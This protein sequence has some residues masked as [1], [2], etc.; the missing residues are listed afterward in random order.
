MPA[1]MMKLGDYTFSLDTAVYQ[2]TSRTSQ[3]KWPEQPRIGTNPYLQF[4]GSGADTLSL[5]G[6]I[7]PTFKGGVK[8]VERMREEAVKG[9]PLQLID[10]SGNL[11]G[12]W[13]ITS[14]KE[15]TSEFLN[16]GIPQKINFTLD[17]KF[18]DK[19]LKRTVREQ[20]AISG[21]GGR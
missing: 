16:G 20:M 10:G 1:A 12:L 18:F 15:K 6:V 7:L 9:T 8:Q 13:C 4:T 11:H 19:S 2:S 3:Y 5:E 21:L 17:L 14:I